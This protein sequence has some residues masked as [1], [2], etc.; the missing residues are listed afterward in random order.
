MNTG[1]VTGNG[2]HA[3]PRTEKPKVVI[4]ATH[5]SE[6][7]FIFLKATWAFLFFATRRK[8]NV[9]STGT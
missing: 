7:G 2:V 9:F 8:R 3:Q 1:A 4:T 6:N 5:L